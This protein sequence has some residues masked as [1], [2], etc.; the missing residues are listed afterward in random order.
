MDTSKMFSL[1]L[2][3]VAKGCVVAVLAVVLGAIQQAVSAHG[4]DVGSYDWAS[5]GKL[6][7]G[8]AGSYL[9]KNLLSDE[10]GKVFGA[11]G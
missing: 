6:A 7:A 8:A 2:K 11:I 4:I 9:L 1:D 10:D 5:I 3:D